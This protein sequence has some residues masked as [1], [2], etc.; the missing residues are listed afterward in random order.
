MGLQ[1]ARVS[2]SVCGC[3][4][5]G[6]TSVIHNLLRR[7]DCLSSCDVVSRLITSLSS[8]KMV[9]A[10]PLVRGDVVASSSRVCS[11]LVSD[12]KEF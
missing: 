8:E 5:L 3:P 1:E 7:S 9:S 12:T 6:R 11:T 2:E 4:I 10:I